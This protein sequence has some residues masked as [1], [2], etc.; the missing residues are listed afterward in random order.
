MKDSCYYSLYCNTIVQ[1]LLETQKKSNKDGLH[2]YYLDET[3]LMNYNIIKEALKYE[4]GN[5]IICIFAPILLQIKEK[6]KNDLK[7][8]IKA[9]KNYKKIKF[10]LLSVYLSENSFNQ[11]NEI[12]TSINSAINFYTIYYGDDLLKHKIILENGGF[13]KENPTDFIYRFIT[14]EN[15]IS[16]FHLVKERY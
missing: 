13:I 9:L 14:S 2:I 6:F 1:Y 3:Q 11:I 12:L 7:D 10:E 5:C 8:F 4:K 15:L 16:E